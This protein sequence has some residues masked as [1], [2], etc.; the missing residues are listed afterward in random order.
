MLRPRRQQEHKQLN[1]LLILQQHPRPVSAPEPAHRLFVQTKLKI[2]ILQNTSLKKN[3]EKKRNREKE[4][5][6]GNC[7][8]RWP[9]LHSQFSILPGTSWVPNEGRGRELGKVKLPKGP[10][11]EMPHAQ[12][13]PSAL[14]SSLGQGPSGAQGQGALAESQPSGTA[15]LV[16]PMR[17]MPRAGREDGATC[18][19]SAEPQPAPGPLP[20]RRWPSWGA[21]GRG[22]PQPPN[23]QG[24][25]C[26]SSRAPSP[27]LPQPGRNL[28]SGSQPWEE[29]HRQIQHKIHPRWWGCSTREYFAP[30]LLFNQRKEREIFIVSECIKVTLG[31]VRDVDITKHFIRSLPTV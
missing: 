1:P 16:L 27:S 24:N 10:A 22:H 30:W 3:K 9:P 18:S 5:Q 29:S 26:T 17:L 14:V 28:S 12:P 4:K 23:Q 21:A 31:F 11:A 6:T 15:G 13:L 8:T 7:Q 2:S 25:C 20:G 19:T